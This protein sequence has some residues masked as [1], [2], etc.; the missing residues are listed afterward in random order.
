[1]ASVNNVAPHRVRLA[2]LGGFSLAVGDRTVTL[3]PASERLLA[4][5]AVSCR[6]AVP[7]ALVAGSLWPEAPERC[8]HANLRSTLARLGGVGRTAL[9]ITSSALRLDPRVSVDFHGARALATIVLDPRGAE[10]RRPGFGASAVLDLSADL[11]PGWYEDWVLQEAE[12]WRQLRTYALEKLAGDFLVARRH[13]EAVIAAHAA[14]RADPLRESSRLTLIRAHLAE[15][16]ASQ[17][18]REYERYARRLRAET[19]VGPPDRLRRLMAGD[20]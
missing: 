9:D 3:P 16:N 13:P 19:G 4:F 18:R 17:A 12:A 15:G 10:P 7:R 1:M 8:A 5:V 2:L 20:G 11:L 14:V 6:G